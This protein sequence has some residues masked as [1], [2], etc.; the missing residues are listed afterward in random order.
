ML[1]HYNF[2]ID[3]GA[4]LDLAFPTNSLSEQEEKDIRNLA[5]PE[6]CGASN[7]SDSQMFYTFRI[8]HKQQEVI[9]LKHISANSFHF[10]YGYVLFR[11]KKDSQLKR[12]WFQ[13]SFV[14]ISELNLS[15]FF[16]KLCE[17]IAENS[18]DELSTFL[19]QLFNRSLHCWPLPIPGTQV[20]VKLTD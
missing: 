11:K 19:E 2:D 10:S 18:N 14:V 1:L 8:R 20:H 15:A 3:K 16:Y 13:D 7:D 6:V 5:F 9:S 17:L 4:V 12:G